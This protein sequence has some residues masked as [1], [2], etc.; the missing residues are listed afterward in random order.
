[1]NSKGF[2]GLLGLIIT[3]A[4]ISFLAYIMLTRYFDQS[5]VTMDA[6]A[7]EAVKEAGINTS[8]QRTVL[9][10]TKAKIKDIEKMQQ[11][12][13]DTLIKRAYEQ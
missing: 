10:S 8:T 5:S 13:A 4:I 3:A 11:Q 6:P 1:M 12:Q 7:Q 2:V 9:E